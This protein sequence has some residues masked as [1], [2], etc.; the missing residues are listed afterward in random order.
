MVAEDVA[1][2]KSTCASWCCRPCHNLANFLSKLEIPSC[3][4]FSGEDR[5]NFFKKS[6][7]LAEGGRLN[8]Q[9]VKAE[10]VKV[11]K[12]TLSKEKKDAQ[13]GEFLPL[14]VWQQRGF[15]SALIEAH[16]DKEMHKVLGATYSVDLHK[17][18]TASVAKQAEEEISRMVYKPSKKRPQSPPG[19]GAE[20]E[21]DVSEDEEAE[22][23]SK[24]RSKL[25]K[26]EKDAA[27]AQ[28]RAQA[29]EA[30]EIEKANRTLFALATKATG[31]LQTCQKS[32]DAALRK[33]VG[34]MVQQTLESGLGKLSTWSKACSVCL[35]SYS[36]NPSVP[37][38]LPF[39][40]KSL[41]A[42]ISATKEL[43]STLVTKPAVARAK[44]KAKAKGRAAAKNE[45]EEIPAP[46]ETLPDTQPAAELGAAGALGETAP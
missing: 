24:K 32:L 7:T 25:S 1:I 17:I 36:S 2:K 42:E 35:Q 6:A 43:I 46:E 30:K 41:E 21:L 31:R 39:D 3:L 38:S 15:D 33:N 19:Q 40:K 22:G 26:E 37:L 13:E 29:K 11:R 16:A 23:P 4:N 20:S 18:C 45:D 10:F 9:R 34:P 12:V 27:R 44:A 8:L 28:Q 5:T 14:S